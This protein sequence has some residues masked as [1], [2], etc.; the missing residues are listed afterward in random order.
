MP[1]WNSYR[2]SEIPLDDRAV[3]NFVAPFA[4][5]DKGAARSAEQFLRRAVDR[6]GDFR[7]GSWS[8]LRGRA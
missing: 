8:S 3:P 7:Q 6:N 2:H 1:T 5:S 4:L